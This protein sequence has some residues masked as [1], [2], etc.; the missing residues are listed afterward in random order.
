MSDV[1]TLHEAIDWALG[2]AEIWRKKKTPYMYERYEAL[3]Q[4]ARACL[5]TKL[6]KVWRVESTYRVDG[7]WRAVA[8][9]YM[10][11]ADADDEA[12]KQ[13]DEGTYFCIR[14]TGPH[15]QEIPA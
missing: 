8:E 11:R 10:S 12:R 5:P 2:Q 4:A 7:T 15:E 13:Y 3:A 14:V 9:H 6:I 1:T